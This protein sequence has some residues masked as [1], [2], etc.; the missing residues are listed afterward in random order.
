[1]KKLLVVLTV[2][3]LAGCGSLKEYIPSR[4]DVNQAKVVTDLRQQTINFDCKGDLKSQL[5]AIES[6]A[7][8]YRLYSEG[9]GTNDVVKMGDTLATTAKEFDERLD[10]GS[11][12][13]VYCDLKKKLMIQQADIMARAVQ[14][15]F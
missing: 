13:P 2:V 11:V 6:T 5:K 3:V 8:W 7:Q 10:K 1:M 4:W 9:K 15:R 14:G 12:S